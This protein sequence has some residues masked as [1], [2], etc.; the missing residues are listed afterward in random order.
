MGTL[1]LYIVTSGS[2]MNS[3]TQIW[4]AGNV[5]SGSSNLSSGSSDVRLYEGDD[6]KLYIYGQ[7]GV[8]LRSTDG[9]NSFTVIFPSA[10]SSLASIAAISQTSNTPTSGSTEK[11]IVVFTSGSGGNSLAYYQ[12]PPETTSGWKAF[13][14]VPTGSFNITDAI[15]DTS[16]T[17]DLLI[18]NDPTDL[19]TFQAFVTRYTPT[20]PF[21]SFQA[22]D[23]G[24]RPYNPELLPSI[25]DLDMSA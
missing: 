17:I 14:N 1:D 18:G 6:G 16:Q 11:N 10:L 25:L 21:N 4:T 2:G 22:S 23:G 19:N 24:I 3:A 9:G 20:Q 12:S 7:K 13:G 5:T 15:F 8:L